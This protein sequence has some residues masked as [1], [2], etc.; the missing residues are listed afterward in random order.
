MAL[1]RMW[2]ALRVGFDLYPIT[3]FADHKSP[4][5]RLHAD[6]TIYR[7]QPC[8]NRYLSKQNSSYAVIR[9]LQK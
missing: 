9:Y 2:A 8:T 4:S 5:L 7:H 6:A 3:S 1:S